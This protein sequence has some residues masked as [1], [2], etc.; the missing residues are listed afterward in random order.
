[1]HNQGGYDD[2]DEEGEAVSDEPAHPVEY[3][4]EDDRVDRVWDE[5]KYISYNNIRDD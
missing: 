3:R 4:G 1:M 2:V 5:L